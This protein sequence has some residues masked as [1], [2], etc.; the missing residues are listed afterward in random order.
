MPINS[1]LPVI[2]TVKVLAGAGVRKM[3]Y[4]SFDGFMFSPI[5]LGGLAHDISDG[6]LF[7]EKSDDNYSYYDAIKNTIYLKFTSANTIEEEGMIVHEATHT[8]FDFQG[9]TMTIAASEALAYIA[10]CM[11]VQ[12]NGSFDPN[13]PDDRLGSWEQDKLTGEWK[14][15]KRDGVFKTGWDIA[16]KIIAGSSTGG[17]FE[18]RREDVDSMK[19]AVK[20]HPWYASKASNYTDYNGFR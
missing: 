12:L 19:A 2:S 1:I 20:S 16:K 4:F 8:M 5:Y 17:V 3:K 9:K 10:Q 11:Y 14:E 13:N 18:V 6:Y 15:T 7:I